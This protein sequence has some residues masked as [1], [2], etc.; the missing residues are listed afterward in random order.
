M[1]YGKTSILRALE[2]AD[3][4]AC[5]QWMNDPEVTHWL[6]MRYPLSLQ[7]ERQWIEAEHNPQKEVHFAATTF[8]GRLIGSCGLI[9]IDP[10]SRNAELGISIGEKDCWN[11]G[12]GKDMMITLCAYGFQMLNLHKIHLRVAAPNLRAIK[13]YEK[14]GFKEEGRLREGFFEHGSYH[15]LVLMGLFAQEHKEN[16]SERWET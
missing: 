11:Q 5:H 1:Y 7:Q 10:V 2:T 4:E 3:T 13:C 14:C 6:G 15:D 16:F 12:F 9:N 8:D